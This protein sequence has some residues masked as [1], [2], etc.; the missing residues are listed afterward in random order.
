MSK[1]IQAAGLILITSLFLYTACSPKSGQP[2]TNPDI[3][4]T[5]A[6]QTV[7]AQLTGVAQPQNPTVDVNL[8]YTSAAQTMEV[9]LTATAIAGN[10]V[11]PTSNQS[12]PTLGLTSSAVPGG[13][14]PGGQP[15]VTTLTP[16][17]IA[18]FT[19]T[20][21]P[22]SSASDKYE[23]TGQSPADNASIARVTKFDMTWTIKNTGTT[24]WTTL[25]TIEFFQGDRISG[26]D[27]DGK[28]RYYFPVEVP[29]GGT[30]SVFVDMKT[31][32][33]AGTYYS[34]WKLKNELGANFGD[35]DVTIEVP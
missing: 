24:T 11:A 3:V 1:K 29:P 26:G 14:T 12:I 16:F 25:Y 18:T 17:S 8:I 20:P 21:P 32:N 30:V 5:A 31:P 2:T 6:A 7:D 4:Y 9:Q 28:N 34:W 35:V 27:Y 33:A 19:R 13:S 23:L 15:V 22:P 10:L